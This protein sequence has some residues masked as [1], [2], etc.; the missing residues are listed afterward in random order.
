M[1]GRLTALIVGVSSDIGLALAKHWAS[2]GV[3]VIG[4]YR[5]MS[6]ELLISTDLFSKL[7][8]CD[9]AD[10]DSI[11]SFTNEVAAQSIQW[12]I[13]IICPGTMN[14]IGQFSNCNIDE[15]EMG[16]SINLL[17]PLRILHGLLRFKRKSKLLPLVIFFAGGGVNSAPINYSSYTTSKIALI[18]AVE[19]L[20]NELEDIRVSIIGPGWVE[21]KIHKETILA[22]DK[23]KNAAEETERRLKSGDFNPMKKVIACIDWLLITPKESIGGRNFSVV[24]DQWGN[25]ELEKTLQADSSKFKL[26]RYGNN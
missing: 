14:P 5:T 22:H 18:K 13:L 12:D 2:S 24:H 21:T 25:C 20:D 15:W 16:V 3:D 11:N 26:R 23:A 19:L 8:H 17:S 10:K 1:R 4:S 6:N 7:L 9:F